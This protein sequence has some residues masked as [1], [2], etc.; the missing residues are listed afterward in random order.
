MGWIYDSTYF[1]TK[2]DYIE[3]LKEI[4]AYRSLDGLSFDFGTGEILNNMEWSNDAYYSMDIQDLESVIEHWDFNSGDKKRSNRKQRLH[5]YYRGQIDQVK[6]QRLSTMTWWAVMECEGR[7]KRCYIGS[8]TS[9][10]KKVSNKIVRK[11]EGNLSNGN[12][13]RRLFDYKWEIW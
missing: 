3:Q 11:Y 7:Y 13:Y 8:R 6:L 9:F 5:K 4:E 2:Q 1:K 10:L 12:Q